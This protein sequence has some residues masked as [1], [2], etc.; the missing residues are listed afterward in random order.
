MYGRKEAPL[1]P[2]NGHTLVVGI[3]ARISGCANQKELSLDDQVDHAKQVV[4]EMFGGPVDYRVIKTTGKGERLDRPELADIEAMLRRRELDLL[5]AEDLGRLVRGTAAKDLCGVAVDHGTRVLAPND[6]VDTADETWEEDVIA[7]CRDHVGHNSHTAKRLKPKLTNRFLKFGGA[8]ARPIAGYVV[9]PDATTYDDWRR[10]DAATPVVAE[11]L[12]RLRAG[13]NCQAVAEYFNAA[14]YAGGTGFPPG[15]YCRRPAWDGKMV[16]RYYKNRLLGGAPGRGYRH[17]VKR[18]ETGRRVSVPN[19]KGP[20][21]RDCP[22]LAHVDLADLDAVNVMLDARNGKLGRPGGGGRARKRTR[23]PGGVG[24]CGYCGRPHVWGGNGVSGNLMCA[25]SRDWRCWCS[26]GYGGAAAVERAVAAVA[27]ALFELEGFDDQFRALIAKA[28]AGGG[29][30]AGRRAKLARDEA[31]LVDRTRNV[32]ETMA[33]LGPKPVVLDAVARLEAEGLRL[34]AER[35]DLDRQAG[36]PPV[37]PASTAELRAAFEEQCRRLARDSRE[38]NDL[39]RALVPTFEVYLVRLADG[40][41]PLPR[42]ELVVRLDALAPDAARV[43]GLAEL[44]T[45]RRTVDLFDPP[46]RERIRPA[47]VALT[48]EGLDQRAVARRLGVSQAAVQKALTLQAR[49]TA[50]GLGTPYQVLSEPPADYPKLRRHRNNNYRFEPL[51][52]HQG[53]ATRA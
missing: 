44:M 22:H 15:P 10:D 9:P 34:A 51:D 43:P 33:A 18:H 30:D 14:P 45:R 38:F 39:L 8:T 47:A 36:R 26:V 52:G 1:V 21:F 53:I 41:H 23:F 7:A 13:G 6:F 4:A 27:D 37:L 42:A 17:T 16:R 5:I 3:V 20:R 31:A 28:A 46:Q 25:G 2:R 19:P 11:G 49:M 40:G 24:A 35:R 32:Q 29:D 50:A 48:A 12:A